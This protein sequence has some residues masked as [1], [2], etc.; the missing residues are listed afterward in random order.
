MKVP[1]F[2]LLGF[3]RPRDVFGLAL[4]ER[5]RGVMDGVWTPGCAS[6]CDICRAVGDRTA[7]SAWLTARARFLFALRVLRPALAA[8]FVFALVVPAYV[9]TEPQHTDETVGAKLLILA[10]AS[11]AGLLAATWRIART[12]WATRRLAR[13]WLRRAEPVAVEGVTIPA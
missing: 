3:R 1:K 2:T 6:A 4:G 10:A 13:E 12:W 11:A 9:L 8:A 7:Y 5:E